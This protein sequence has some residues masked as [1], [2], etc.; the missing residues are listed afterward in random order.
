MAD[1]A[2]ISSPVVTHTAMTQRLP[3]TCTV[4]V[5]MFAIR[6]KAT[7]TARAVTGLGRHR[8]PLCLD[9]MP[10]ASQMMKVRQRIL[11]GAQAPQVIAAHTRRILLP[12]RGRRQVR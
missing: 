7:E 11:T 12:A 2:T 6:L 3:L 8:R 1:A 4:L 9:P 10:T 5:A